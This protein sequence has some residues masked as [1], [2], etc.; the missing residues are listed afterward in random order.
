MKK[1]FVFLFVI[2]VWSCSSEKKERKVI[3]VHARGASFQD[4]SN[5]LNT[6]D[7]DPFKVED[8]QKLKPITNAVT[9]SNIAS[10]E[11]GT[12][13]ASHGIV[14]HFYAKG[15]SSP[16]VVSGFN[17]RFEVPAFWEIADEAGMKVLNLGSLT[18]HGKTTQHSNVDCLGQGK[19][20]KGPSFIRLLPIDAEEQC[21]QTVDSTEERRF[22]LSN[23]KTLFV[24]FDLDSTNGFFTKIQKCGWGKVIE[25]DANATRSYLIKWLETKG[26]TLILYQRATF[27]SRGYPT[28]FVRL[29]DSIQGPAIGWPNIP[30]YTSGKL[31][32]STVLE[33][34]EFETDFLME[35]FKELAPQNDYDLILIDYPLMDRIGHLFYQNIECSPSQGQL[36]KSCYERLFDDFRDLKEFA[37]SHHYAIIFASTHGF[38]GIHT[39]I[40]LNR[41]LS[42][43][44]LHTNIHVP[45]WQ[46]V[47][48][49]GKVSA[50]LYFNSS[51]SD[52]SRESITQKVKSLVDSFATEGGESIIEAVYTSDELSEI[53][54]NHQNAGDLFILL[55][56]GFVFQ[57]SF[58]PEGDLFLEPA[59]K[60]DHG[61]STRHEESYGFLYSEQRCDECESVDI[62]GMVLK[63]LRLELNYDG[64]SIKHI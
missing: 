59:F 43:H 14:G 8:F 39:S 30:A 19:V 17:E 33:E 10:F 18:L 46:V 3:L 56:P 22:Y 60:G 11:T 6:R 35:N 64:D 1:W 25:Q 21:Y 48:I 32:I 12:Y 38:S 29:A 63:Q 27:S 40:N 47:G 52:S 44:D 26:D 49:P 13:P 55:K 4:I 28:D 2:A 42:N 20:D 61:Y 5:F 36:L 37:R 58:S 7:I 23:D 9:I 31:P 50:H 57:S 53:K 34:V 62:A 15:D 45:N 24:D 41:M 16:Q 54:M 51:I